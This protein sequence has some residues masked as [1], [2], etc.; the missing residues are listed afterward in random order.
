VIDENI[1]RIA[2]IAGVNVYCLFDQVMYRLRE[3]RQVFNDGRTRE[4]AIDTSLGEKLAPNEDTFAG[5]RRAVAEELGVTRL[6]AI[7][8][9]SHSVVERE[10][11]SY[12][13]LWTVLDKTTL[14]VYIDP[15]EFSPQGYSETQADKQTFFEWEAL[16]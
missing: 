9:V 7:E 1:I 13:G 2:K 5:V 12:P 3:V 10:S 4:R 6:N 8:E 16:N 11:G 14:A 15:N